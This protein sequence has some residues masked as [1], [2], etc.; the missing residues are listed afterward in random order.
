MNDADLQARRR[1]DP[2]SRSSAPEPRRTPAV[3]VASHASSLSIAS[4]ML[5]DAEEWLYEFQIDMFAG[6]GCPRV[7]GVREDGVPAFAGYGIKCA[8]QMI[9]EERAAGRALARSRAANHQPPLHHRRYRQVKLRRYRS[10]AFTATIHS[11][12]SLEVVSPD[13]ARM[14][15]PNLSRHLESRHRFSVAK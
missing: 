8:K 10:A 7:H 13:A 9:A 1:A 2:G 4:E 11:R 14:P 6:G 5:G 12:R 15:A 3:Q